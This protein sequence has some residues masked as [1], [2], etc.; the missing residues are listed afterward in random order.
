M[1]E[2][3]PEHMAILRHMI[4]LGEGVTLDATLAGEPWRNHYAADVDGEP[5]RIRHLLAMVDLGLVT[6]GR[7]VNC[8]TMRYFHATRDGIVAAR[9]D[10]RRL[11]D[12]AGVRRWVVSWPEGQRVVL[13]ASR[14]A[15]KW[16]VICGMVEVGATKSWCFRNIRA[17]RGGG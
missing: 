4:G 7:Y 2:V 6:A 14:G 5:I 10:E 11:R 15:A 16:G 13:A 3:M 17:V 12:L 8:G 1:S 9:S